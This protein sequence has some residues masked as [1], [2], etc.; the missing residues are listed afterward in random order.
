MKR[1]CLCL[2]GVCLAIVG[3]GDA[4][5]NP[6]EKDFPGAP[7]SSVAAPVPPGKAPGTTKIGDKEVVIIPQSTLPSSY[8][9][10]G[11]MVPAPAPSTDAPKDR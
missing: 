9:G 11:K 4:T 8:P 6:N 7:G 10:S 1:A 2:A 5:S 3:C